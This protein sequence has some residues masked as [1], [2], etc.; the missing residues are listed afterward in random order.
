MAILKSELTWSFSRNR[1]FKDCRRAY[2]YYYYASWKGWEP[3]SDEFTRKAYLLKNMR[4]IPI[5]IGDIVHQILKWVL[6]RKAANENIS[7]DDALTKAKQLLI[8]TWEQSRSKMWMKNIKYNLNLF[9]HYYNRQP[10]RQELNIKLQKAKLCIVNIY[11]SGLLELFSR[12]PRKSFLRIDEL[13]NFDYEGIK[14]FAVPDFAIHQD[15]YTLYDWKTGKPTDKDTLQLSCYLLY[16]MHK[17]EVPSE[18]IKII[19][20]YLAEQELSFNPITPMDINQLAQY[21]HN[22]VEEMRSV[23][24]DVQKNKADIN[25][26]PKTT[27]PWRC[28]NCKFQEICE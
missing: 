14:I 25:Q 24:S 19:P 1:L 17:W 3:S 5:W 13:D 16:A 15:T 12:L 4:N 6:E 18:K 10:T 2:Y 23:L 22:S 28:K 8:R 11:D 27:D 7:C 21:I 9:E 26:C 20:V